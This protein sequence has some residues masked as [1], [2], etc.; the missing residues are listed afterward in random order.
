MAQ[1]HSRAESE[2]ILGADIVPPPVNWWILGGGL[3]FTAVSLSVGLSRI[4]G[5]EEII[6]AISMSIV[7][8]LMWRLTGELEPEARNV[9]VGTA[10]LDICVPRHT[11]TGCRLNMVDD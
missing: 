3:A 1:G 4:P 5:G 11:G 8:F 9:L 2:A 7:L 6:F 10:V